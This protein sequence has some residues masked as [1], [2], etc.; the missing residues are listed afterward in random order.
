[1]QLFA[2]YFQCLIALTRHYVRLTSPH[3]DDIRVCRSLARSGPL[4]NTLAGD[5][6]PGC[7]LLPVVL[8]HSHAPGSYLPALLSPCRLPPFPSLPHP[9]AS[10]SLTH[11]PR[12]TTKSTI[13]RSLL[14]TN[15]YFMGERVASLFPPSTFEKRLSG[16]RLA[17]LFGHIRLVRSFSNSNNYP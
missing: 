15:A 12:R 5:L 14:N 3:T 10:L 9:C 1:M 11:R 16:K 17:T 8:E 7:E 4:P 6:S 2:N 13:N